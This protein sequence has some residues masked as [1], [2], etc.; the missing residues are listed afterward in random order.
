MRRAMEVM[1][2]VGFTAI[3]SC[4]HAMCAYTLVHKVP[5]T[6]WQPLRVELEQFMASTASGSHSLT[7]VALWVEVW[8]CPLLMI[9]TSKAD[10]VAG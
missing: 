4:Q 6:L 7:H 1:F 3:G 8:G 10:N 5:H 2:S 9:M